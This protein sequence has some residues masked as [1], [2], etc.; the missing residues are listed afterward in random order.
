MKLN[1]TYIYNSGVQALTNN[2]WKTFKIGVNV[3]RST[4][5]NKVLL[6]CYLKGNNV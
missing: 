6:N 4:L 5:L 3:R 1:I 2:V